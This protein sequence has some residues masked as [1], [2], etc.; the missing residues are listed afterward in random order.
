M[1]HPFNYHPWLFILNARKLSIGQR[2]EVVFVIASLR[3]FHSDFGQSFCFWFRFCAF[4]LHSYKFLLHVLCYAVQVAYIWT[5]YQSRLNLQLG[6]SQKRN[7]RQ[8]DAAIM[9]H[10]DS[11]CGFSR[12]SRRPH[13]CEVT[14]NS[15][16][17]LIS[18]IFCLSGAFTS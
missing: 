4:V 2:T 17:L 7:R 8:V 14:R 9:G 16:M 15:Y 5:H 1:Q 11:I 10:T 18:R 12:I 3:V 6:C 13:C